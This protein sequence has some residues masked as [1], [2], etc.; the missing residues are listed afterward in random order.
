MAPFEVVISNQG[1]DDVRSLAPAFGNCHKE[2][3]VR[4][5]ARFFDRHDWRLY[6]RPDNIV[7]PSSAAPL[8]C[9]HP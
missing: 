8:S 2:E 7:S 3:T 1:R 5:R 6:V 9:A 4:R